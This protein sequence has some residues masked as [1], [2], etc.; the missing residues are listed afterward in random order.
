M[1]FTLLQSSTVRNVCSETIRKSYGKIG[2]SSAV[3][4]HA[5]K[6]NV[7]DTFASRDGLKCAMA[8]KSVTEKIFVDGLKSSCNLGERQWVK[9]RWCFF[10]SI[11]TAF[12]ANTP[13]NFA[14]MSRSLNQNHYSFSGSVLVRASVS[15]FNASV[16]DLCFN[17][18]EVLNVI[19]ETQMPSP[20]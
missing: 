18:V 6:R 17:F 8:V 3:G 11:W 7:A 5:K 16:P 13:K 15:A 12:D 9:K 2:Q 19:C 10:K 20:A 1:W 4:I 14:L